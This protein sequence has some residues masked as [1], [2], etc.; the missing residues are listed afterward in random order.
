MNR[1][2]SDFETLCD[3]G[4]RLAGQGGDEAAA[5]WAQAALSDMG[6]DVHRADIA[7]DAWRCE[8]ADLSLGGTKLECKPLL[9]S[10][11]GSVKA[12]VID[13][14]RGAESDFGADVRGKIALVRHEY[15]FSDSHIHR[16]RKYNWALERGCTGFLIAHTELLSGSSGRAI[17]QPGIPAAYITE[18]SLGGREIVLTISGAESEGRAPIVVAD[19]PGRTRDLVVL[20]AHLDGHDLGESALDNATG[21]AVALAVAREL[22][23]RAEL[24]LRVCLFSAEDWALAGSEKYLASMTAQERGRIKLNINLDPVGGDDSL[25]ALISGYAELEGLVQGASRDCGIPI[26]TYLPLMANSDHANF[27]RAGI[28][29]LRLVA[30]FNRP[31]SKVRHILSARDTR[32]QVRE[33]ELLSAARA[34]GALVALGMRARG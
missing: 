5:R 10:A 4:G 32:A 31:E 27:A 23:P 11:A 19:F 26:A 34:A 20:S 33:E 16:R 7:F 8:R 13:L 9:R 14:G 22:G 17:G 12:Q 25:T 1:L 21:V 29:A 28:P 3:F 15:P 30:G 6:A 18:Q 2:W 24:G